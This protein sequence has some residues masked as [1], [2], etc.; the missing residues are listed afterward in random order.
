M[1]PT[2]EQLQNRIKW[3]EALR[4]GEYQQGK[5][6]LRK[7]E[8]FC[9][10]GVACDVFKA[11][12]GV[13]W[14]NDQC[15]V[16]TFLGE[17][18]VLPSA[19]QDCLALTAGGSLDKRVERRAVLW[20]LNDSLDYS[21]DQIAQVIEDQFITPYLH[22]LATPEIESTERTQAENAAKPEEK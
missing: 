11:Q 16:F 19:V 2:L 14:S 12:I 18:N 22:L 3:V 21:F 15:G 13:D 1:E 20:S 8:R 7:G 9:C 5:G 17:R 6:N 4:S 10:L